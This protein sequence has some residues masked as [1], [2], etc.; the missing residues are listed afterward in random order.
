MVLRQEQV[1]N[2]FVGVSALEMGD[3][4]VQANI[5]DCLAQGPDFRVCPVVAHLA[6]LKSD[7]EV[8]DRF[9]LLGFMVR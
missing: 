7:L 9:H 4:E 6:L 8:F 5:G 2:R 1:V 3:S